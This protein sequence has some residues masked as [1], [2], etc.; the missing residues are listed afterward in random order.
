M[1]VRD[2]IQGLHA[3][4]PPASSKNTDARS[5]G[6]ILQKSGQVLLG[7]KIR[8]KLAFWG[9]NNSPDHQKNFFLQKNKK[10]NKKSEKSFQSGPNLKSFAFNRGGRVDL[11]APKAIGG[12]KNRVGAQNQRGWG[13]QN[14]QVALFFFQGGGP[15]IRSF[16]I[17]STPD[18]VLLVQKQSSYTGIRL[19]V[20]S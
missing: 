17:I 3:Q 4:F 12:P 18:Y 19:Y 16:G 14:P 8:Q 20:T 7:P 9:P 10:N 2:P 13:A 6:P 5:L 11:R 15:K 1:A